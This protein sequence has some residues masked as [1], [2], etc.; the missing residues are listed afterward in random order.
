MQSVQLLCVGS[1][2]EPFYRAGCAEYEKRLGAYCKLKVIE[3]PEARLHGESDRAVS[4]VLNREG[5]KFLPYLAGC[6][7]IALC[8]EGEPVTSPGI[9]R[10]LETAALQGHSRVNLLIGGSWG[11]SDEVKNR[12]GRLVSLGGITLPHQLCR[13]VVLE[14][15]YRAYSIL[16]KSSYHK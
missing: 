9:A 1:L 10:L 4:S 7:N 13:L 11:L 14:Q 8:L 5:E 3:L 12:C 6:Y 15:L 2:K 16:A